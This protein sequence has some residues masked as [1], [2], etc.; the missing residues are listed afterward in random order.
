MKKLIFFSL[1]IIYTSNTIAQ[2]YQK[3]ISANGINKIKMDFKFPEVIKIST[4]EK[5]EVSIAGKVSIN[6]GQNNESFEIKTSTE[7]EVL[8]ISSIINDIDQLPKMIMIKKNGNNYYFNTTDSNSPEIQQFYKEHGKS[9]NYQVHGVIKQIE[10]EIRVPKSL[11]L[12]INS[13]YG[14]VELINVSSPVSVIAKYGGVDVSVNSTDR[15]SIT[16]RTKFGEMFSDLQLSIDP[17]QSVGGDYFK[18]Q[19]I[20][21]ELNG[22]GSN[23][24]IES[25]FGNIYI[26]KI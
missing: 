18:W 19:T 6:N 24:D 7:N 16:A 14:I 21:A 2:S 12:E 17:Q 4:W 13:K 10:L 25:K 8:N 11:E 15:W 20:K 26:R 23:C 5:Q 1:L 9:H 22:G 3:D